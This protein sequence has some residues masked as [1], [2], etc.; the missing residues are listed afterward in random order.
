MKIFVGCCIWLEIFPEILKDKGITW[1]DKA[2]V[3]LLAAAI[4]PIVLVVYAI[5]DLIYAAIFK[6][7]V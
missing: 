5:L 3:I 4:T 6:R 1:F 7:N 2:L